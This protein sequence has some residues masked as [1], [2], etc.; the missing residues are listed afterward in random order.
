VQ[1]KYGEQVNIVGVAGRDDL[2]AME[3]F[4]SRTGTDSIEHVADIT[5]E[6]WG[7]YQIVSQPAWAFINDDGTV[8]TNLGALGADGIVERIEDLL[9]K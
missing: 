5:G 9:A 7:D 2:A 1:E 3:D 4:V 8:E 6:I